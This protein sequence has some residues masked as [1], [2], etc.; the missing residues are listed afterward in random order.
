M[1]IISPSANYWTNGSALVP[2]ILEEVLTSSPVR[3]F[4]IIISLSASYW[5]NSCALVPGSQA[6]NIAGS[7]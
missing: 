7:K 1:I 4:A 2:D 5:T 6:K 3:G